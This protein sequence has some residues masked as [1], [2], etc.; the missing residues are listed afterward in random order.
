[1]VRDYRDGVIETLADSEHALAREAAGLRE[2]LHAAVEQV[3]ALTV[4]R[5]RLQARLWR[6]LD[7][8]RRQRTERRG[9]KAAR[10]A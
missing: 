9:T 5:N 8:I 4:E 2:V 7:V 3:H 1:M 6:A 10:A